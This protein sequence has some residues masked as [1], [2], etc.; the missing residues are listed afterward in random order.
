MKE[1]RHQRLHVVRLHS[2]RILEEA[3]SSAVTE[4]RL[5]MGGVSHKRGSRKL[6]ETAVMFSYVLCLKWSDDFMG[7]DTCQNIA[8]YTL[9]MCS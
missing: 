2:H 4:S 3:K 8:L 9:N 1:A 7:G 5:V 6:L